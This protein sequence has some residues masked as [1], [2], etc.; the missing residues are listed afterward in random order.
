[1]ET[2][3]LTRSPSD[4]IMCGVCGGLGRYL[5][6]DSTFVRA[7]AVVFLL[8]ALPQMALLY[9]ALWVIVPLEGSGESTPDAVAREGAKELGA[10]AQGFWATCTAF[11]QG[12]DG[13]W[14]TGFIIIL[15]GLI[16]FA[17]VTNFSLLGW[18]DWDLLAPLAI[19]ALGFWVMSRGREAR[20]AQAVQPEPTTPDQPDDEG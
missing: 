17:D 8:M 1:M 5:G 12:R 9:A 7:V 16:M 18:L 4:K 14:F 10:S 19:L 15:V 11:C 2:K 6:L 3:R 20:A 13:R